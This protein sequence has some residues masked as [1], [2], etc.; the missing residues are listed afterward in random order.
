MLKA[1]RQRDAARMAV[2]AAEFAIIQP[3]QRITAQVIRDYVLYVTGVEWEE[4]A[5]P[6]RAQKLV[7]IRHAMIFLLH[8]HCHHLSLPAIGR[9]VGNRDH[10]TIFSAIKNVEANPGRYAY[11]VGPAKKAL[12]M[13]GG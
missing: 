12:G 13:E 4:I 9:Y 3:G 8:K 11:I 2:K 7:T 5:G 1:E 6:R 10:S